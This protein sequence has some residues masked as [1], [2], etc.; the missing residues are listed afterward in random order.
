MKFVV[1]VLV[2]SSLLFASND[3]VHNYDKALEKAQAQNKKIYMLITS[4]ACRWCKKFENV[5]LKDEATMKMLKKDYVLL[6]LNRSHDKIP[7]K[8]TAKRVPR[9]FF[10]T[11]EG[12]EIYSFLGYWNPEDF[13]SFVVEVEK[14]VKK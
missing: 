2:L 3:F 10:L 11:R 4:D 7:A 14:K 13:A 9:H 12:E 8:F 6:A 5:T 1:T